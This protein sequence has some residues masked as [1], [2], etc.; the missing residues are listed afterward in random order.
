MTVATQAEAP[1]QQD[2]AQEPTPQETKQEQQ[3]QPTSPGSSEAAAAQESKAAST[4]KSGTP[5]ASPTKGKAAASKTTASKS[6]A[7]DDSGSADSSPK[8]S[9]SGKR[10]SAATADAP[11]PRVTLETL[12][13]RSTR[14]LPWAGIATGQAVDEKE[15]LTSAEMLEKFGLNWDVDTE[16]MFVKRGNKFVQHPR[17]RSV[18]R[19]DNMDPIGVVRSHYETFANQD[20]FA[21]GDAIVEEGKGRWTQAGMQ[22]DG[23][24]VFMTMLLDNFTVLDGDP[25]EMY[26]FFRTGH[27]G[28]ASLG[29][30]VVPFDVGCLNQTAIAKAKAKMSWNIQHTSSMREKVADAQASL[31][32][33]ADYQKD[34]QATVSR[35][36]LKKVTPAR[37]KSLLDELIPNR[38]SRRDKM[39]EDILQVH[40]ISPTVAP[41]KGTAYG[42]LKAVTEY[43]DHVKPQR[44]DNARFEAIMWGEGAKIRANLAHAIAA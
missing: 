20:V 39:I 16:P 29:A 8:A 40:A 43:M 35:L 7:T 22:G 21:M 18:F 28:G 6:T 2:T 13:E 30:H 37:A 11:A 14:R 9:G 12:P 25:F 32:M 27:D 15:L 42:L 19:T 38:R 26:L 31:R 36:A 4:K 23:V 44:S 34:L 1:E 24:R 33:V 3:E 41:Y 10:P 5:K 17:A